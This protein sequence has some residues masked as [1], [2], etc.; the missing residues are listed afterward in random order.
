MAAKLI[1][2]S[3]VNGSSGRYGGAEHQSICW[4]RA[5]KRVQWSWWQPVKYSL[6]LGLREAHRFE[7]TCRSISFPLRSG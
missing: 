5:G 3:M 1:L 7:G 2:E 4:S 6:S